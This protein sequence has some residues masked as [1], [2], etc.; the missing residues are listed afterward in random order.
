M[1]QPQELANIPYDGIAEGYF[2]ADKLSALLREKYERFKKLVVKKNVT[3][4]DMREI[5]QIEIFLDEIPD[6]LASDITTEYQ[7]LKSEFEARE[8]L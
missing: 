8:D 1:N 4:E 7:P 2:R 5:S 3:D 6:Y